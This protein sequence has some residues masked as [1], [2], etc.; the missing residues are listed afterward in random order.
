MRTMG[1]RENETIEI[2]RKKANETAETTGEKVN[3]TTKIIGIKAIATTW[4]MIFMMMRTVAMAKMT[5]Y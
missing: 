1:I 5:G 4:T 2:M 3:A